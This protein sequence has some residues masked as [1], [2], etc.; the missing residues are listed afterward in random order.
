MEMKP[1][2]RSIKFVMFLAVFVHICQAQRVAQDSHLQ[3]QDSTGAYKSPYVAFAL[4]TIATGAPIYLSF[5]KV[6]GDRDAAFYF[7]TG[8]MIGPG[9]GYMYGNEWNRALTGIGIRLGCA[10]GTLLMASIATNSSSTPPAMVVVAVVG[11]A[12]TG[13]VVIAIDALYDIITVGSFIQE[14]NEARH[15]LRL[16]IVPTVG[17]NTAG[18]QLNL[19]F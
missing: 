3:A 6:V 11:A 12:V 17:R 19:N 10:A 5:A 16:S 18:L 14:R 2:T 8:L 1:N 13:L 9:V 4:S 7:L 15:A